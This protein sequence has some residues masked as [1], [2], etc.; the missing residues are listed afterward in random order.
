M[1]HLEVGNYLYILLPEE[2]KGK[3]PEGMFMTSEQD[4]KHRLGLEE[5]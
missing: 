5:V 4:V 3:I 1:L 2:E